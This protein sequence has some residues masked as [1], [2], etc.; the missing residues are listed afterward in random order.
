MNLSPPALGKKHIL[1]LSVVGGVAVLPLLPATPRGTLMNGIFLALPLALT[2]H[3]ASAGTLTCH[4]TDENSQKTISAA[5]DVSDNEAVAYTDGELGALSFNLDSPS[6]NR[7]TGDCEVNCTFNS[8]KIEDEV[9]QTTVTF[10][11]RQ[12]G[13]DVYVDT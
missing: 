2:A 9:G 12:P 11:K 1:D 7:K 8:S 6:C 10:S 3:L 4:L 13:K 5:I